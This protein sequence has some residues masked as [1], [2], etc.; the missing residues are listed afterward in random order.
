[1]NAYNFKA[2]GVTFRPGYPGTLLRLHRHI[3]KAEETEIMGGPVFDPI[4]VT[5]TRE[6]ENEYDKNAIALLLPAEF[7]ATHVGYVPKNLAVDMAKL[8]DQGQ[9]INATVR[10]VDIHPDYPDKPG[11]V[12]KVKWTE[13]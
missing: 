4:P 5:L 7:A 9:Q 12:I 10:S 6:P 11:L 2:A 3:E 8:L 1:M 13:L